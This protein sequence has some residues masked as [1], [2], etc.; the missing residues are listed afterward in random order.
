LQ[1]RLDLPLTRQ[2]RDVIRRRDVVVDVDPMGRG[3][4]RLC[5]DLILVEDSARSEGRE[6]SQ[7]FPPSWEAGPE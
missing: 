6:S 4:G 5:F 7:K 1:S 3:A 2:F